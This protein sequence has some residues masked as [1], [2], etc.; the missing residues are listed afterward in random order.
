MSIFEKA[1]AAVI[2]EINRADS[3]AGVRIAWGGRDPEHVAKLKEFAAGDAPVESALLE[4]GPLAFELTCF[5]EPIGNVPL[6]MLWR[7]IDPVWVITGS[8]S[9]VAA[10]TMKANFLGRPIFQKTEQAFGICGLAAVL[11]LCALNRESLLVSID[12]ADRAHVIG[13]AKA[14]GEA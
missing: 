7:K 9:D 10:E 12:Q 3:G 8:A 2:D 13:S 1:F 6:F 4:A 11:P 14:R 5:T